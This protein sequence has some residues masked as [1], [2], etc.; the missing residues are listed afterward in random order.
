MQNLSRKRCVPCEGGIDPLTRDQFEVYL[1]QLPDWTVLDDKSLEREFR[2]KDFVEAMAWVNK[3]AEIA[4]DEGH[5]P[6]IYI[7]GWNKVRITLWTHAIGGLSINDFVVAS[8]ID[9]IR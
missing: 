5:H 9:R 8:K 1:E 7:H 3:V 4:E 2:F 6:D